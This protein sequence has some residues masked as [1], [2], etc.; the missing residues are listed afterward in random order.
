MLTTL[1]HGR[2][3]FESRLS[4]PVAIDVSQATLK[5]LGSSP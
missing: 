4:Q 3:E 2:L 1:R 5:V